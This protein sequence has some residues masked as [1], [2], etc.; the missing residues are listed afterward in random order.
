MSKYETLINILD[1]ILD[2]CPKDRLQKRY[3][4]KTE[5]L[6]WQ[7]RSKAYIHL[8]LM[9]K[10]GILDFEARD[11]FITDDSHDG[12]IDA[13]YIDEDENV[14]YLIQSKFRTNE[15]NFNNKEICY[16]ELI[17]MDVDRIRKGESED[18]N[19]NA[20]NGRI[21][22]LQR[23][24]TELKNPGQYEYKVIILANTKSDKHS[25]R[26]LTGGF[27]AEVF[28]YKK[29]Y[30]ELVFPVVSGNYFSREDLEVS[31]NLINSEH[32]RIKY[33]VNLGEESANITVLFAPTIEIAKILNK[34][35]NSIL[36]YNPRSYLE[37]SGNKVNKEIMNT[38]EK[39]ENNEFALYNNGITIV[40]GS[41]DFSE[42]TGQKNTAKLTLKKPQIINGGQTAFTLS[43]AYEKYLGD[44]DKIRSLFSG[45][46][47]L[48][49][50]ISFN[51]KDFDFF[52]ER[53][54]DEEVLEYTSGQLEIIERVSQATNRQSPI[55]EAD[56][57]ANDKN[58]VKF[59]LYAYE[60]FDMY[61]ERKRGEFG[62][63]LARKF[64][65]R[66]LLIKRED[67]IRCCLSS[68]GKAGEARR[69]NKNYLFKEDVFEK[70]LSNR[71]E[72]YNYLVAYKIFEELK[73]IE[74]R[75][76][77]PGDS[78]S[79]SKYGSA[80]RYGKYAVISACYNYSSHPEKSNYKEVVKSV[81]DKW[82]KFERKVRK[83]ESNKSIFIK[84]GVVETN[85]LNYYK[86]KAV[87]EDLKE[88]FFNLHN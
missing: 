72:Y 21:E 3:S 55:D 27:D 37:L 63:G 23:R 33:N 9:A 13:Y 79:V 22:G 85:M 48:I 41:C 66:G 1:K 82:I 77:K 38:I 71:D 75:D 70:Y 52:D 69:A 87:N 19:G 5:Q 8:F 15:C 16:K 54:V 73:F 25:L 67:M 32:P 42:S 45:K 61:Y 81:L 29:A 39:S 68:D 2:S 60:N 49:K 31:L 26:R 28:D 86:S 40:A 20:Y 62:D 59:Q 51:G 53:T 50:I 30:A 46:E 36:R 57:R 47:V 4:R 10:F 17:A 6:H 14:I 64:I 74:K 58:H 65:E 80:L 76:K 35:K 88:Y 44:K 34:Y 18:E 24:I 84:G 12:G 7:S 56:R 78:F 43:K 83:K 11:Q